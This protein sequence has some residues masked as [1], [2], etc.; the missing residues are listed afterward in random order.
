MGEIDEL[1]KKLKEN[2]KAQEKATSV[3]SKENKA[4]TEE[5]LETK[6]AM[7]ALDKAI[8][9]LVKGSSQDSLLQVQTVSAAVDAVSTRRL[10]SL[11]GKQLSMLH[12][13]VGHKQGYAPQ[14][15]TIQ[16]IL[17]D[18]YETFASDLESATGDE[19]TKN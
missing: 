11:P 15:A 10:E 9:V 14:S 8:T 1:T 6:Q 18:M 12:E 17:G 5:T 2:R 16:G 7:A 3:R 19:G 13:F 4:Y